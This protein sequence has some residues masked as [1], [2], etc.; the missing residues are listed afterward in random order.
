MP[1]PPYIVNL[2]AKIGH[3]WILSPA[4]SV[5][6]F[7]DANEILLQRRSDDGRWGMIGGML[8]PAEDPSDAAIRE[9]YEEAGVEIYLERLVGIY[10]GWQNAHTYPNGNQSAFVTTTYKARILRGQPRV[11]DEESLEL[12][13]FNPNALPASVAERHLLR[14]RHALEN[15]DTYFVLPE[16]IPPAPEISYLQKMRRFV[17]HELLM[18]AGATAIIRN[19][20]GQFLI[21]QRADNGMWNLVGGVS[22][23]AEDPAGTALREGYEETGLFLQIERLLGVYGGQDYVMTYPNQDVVS[24]TNFAFVCSVKSGRLQIDS[25]SL[26][27]EWVNADELPANFDKNHRLLIQHTLEGK[28]AYFKGQ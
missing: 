15:R 25:E 9:A 14:I 20:R 6:I 24:Y 5:V 28:T 1:V 10:S 16:A 21:Q 27:L 23:I 22:E 17:G 3:D 8:D 7:N 26:A 19:E 12:A 18:A 13:F 2:R 11:N 4:A